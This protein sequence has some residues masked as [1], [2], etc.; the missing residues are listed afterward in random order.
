MRKTVQIGEKLKKVVPDINLSN[1]IT[2]QLEAY[3]DL[4]FQWNQKIN[5]TAIRGR[6]EMV[7]KHICDTAVSLSISSFAKILNDPGIRCIDFGSGAGIPGIILA[8]CCPNIKLF[9][10]DKSKKKIA[11]QEQ[12]V[13]SL[14]LTNVYPRAVRLQDLTAGDIPQ[15]AFNLIISRAFDQIKN[16]LYFGEQF[17]QPD[18]SLILWKG[19]SW[20][21]EL[22]QVDEKLLNQFT[23]VCSHRYEFR[24]EDHGGV[25]LH[26]QK[27]S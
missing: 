18:G 13:R 9:S 11:F 23:V 7:V 19:E 15:I 27:N 10:I 14:K 21:E 8:I 16:I 2:L 26:I 12:V 22:D 24:N 1:E 5:L 17:L 4:L 20:K 25:L 3:L 6:Q